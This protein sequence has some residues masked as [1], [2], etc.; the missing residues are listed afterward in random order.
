MQRT[1][2]VFSVESLNRKSLPKRMKAFEIPCKIL[3]V[4]KFIGET[5]S[6]ISV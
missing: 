4:L 2:R 6:M 1:K 3:N 5:L